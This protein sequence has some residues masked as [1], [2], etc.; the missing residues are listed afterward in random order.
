MGWGMLFPVMVLVSQ[1]RGAG[2]LRVA[3]KLI[4]QGLWLCGFLFVPGG[5]ILWHLE[6]ILL[7]TG[8]LPELARVA[9]DYMD[10]RL[11][12]LFM[13]FTTTVFMF[14]F[15]AIGRSATSAVILWCAVGL[16]AI[17]DYALIFG[18]FGLPA[19]GVAGAGLAS[20]IVFG[21]VHMTFFT[22]LAF[23]RFFSHVTL[24]QRAWRP[25]KTTIGQFFR[26]GWPKAL[27]T[28][29]KNSLF[30]VI[31]LLAGWFGVRAVA[32]HT[33]AFQISLVAGIV[34]PAAIAG[35]VTTRMGMVMGGKNRDG[36][37]SI[38]TS[39]ILLLLLFILPAVVALKLFSP[40]VIMLFVG[41]GPEGRDLVSF[42]SPLIV[43]VAV[44]V[45]FDSVRMVIGYALNGLS[46][47]KMPTVIIGL[48]YWGIGLPV[49][50]VLGFTMDLGVLG[51]WWGLTFGMAITA[52]TNLI[53]FRWLVGHLA[54]TV[55]RDA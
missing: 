44:F 47:M 22:H 41:A 14:A 5:A 13:G 19:M 15:T 48:A 37:W 50:A 16:N 23:H 8:Q 45:L 55:V 36:M 28:M 42:A 3:P 29:I 54:T 43:L 32:A 1:A 31:T 38:L 11:W 25:R 7:S 46:D 12:T 34:V 35:A 18:K 27:E 40:Q 51:L 10:Y 53:R 6:E 17:L 39:G 24:F 26:L 30:F 20:V 4:R 21:I 49:G 33:I 9:G 52:I 2:R